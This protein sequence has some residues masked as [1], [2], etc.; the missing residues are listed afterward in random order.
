MGQRSGTIVGVNVHARMGL[1][2]FTKYT[3]HQLKRGL[4]PKKIKTVKL[5][6][7]ETE[8]LE[9]VGREG[10]ERRVLETLD[11]HLKQQIVIFMNSRF[12]HPRIERDGVHVI[13]KPD[14]FVCEPKAAMIDWRGD[15]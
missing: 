7:D 15:R 11:V 14:V 3:V 4:A 2:E 5:D 12:R 9:P 6:D 13:H 10:C 8:L 1:E